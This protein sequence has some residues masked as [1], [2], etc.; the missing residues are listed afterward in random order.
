[1]IVTIVL[2]FVSRGALIG[3]SRNE[4]NKRLRPSVRIS[5]WLFAFWAL[6][7]LAFN[8]LPLAPSRSFSSLAAQHLSA[9]CS[10]QAEDKVDGIIGA[11]GAAPI[12]ILCCVVLVLILLAF[13]SYLFTNHAA[14]VSSEIEGDGFDS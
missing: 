12:L 4:V 8:N 13:V 1:V 10:A 7:G 9:H 6:L 14:H 2:R 11:G 3:P 5:H